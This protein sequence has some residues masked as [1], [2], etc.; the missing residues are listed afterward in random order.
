MSDVHIKICDYSVPSVHGTSIANASIV[1]VLQPLDI[2]GGITQTLNDASATHIELTDNLPKTETERP[3][4]QRTSKV[5][6]KRY[7]LY[8]EQGK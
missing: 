7:R 3:I 6:V 8:K 5:E 2:S 4:Y 1:Q